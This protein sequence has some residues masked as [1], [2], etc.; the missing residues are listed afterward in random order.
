MSAAMPP[1]PRG[2]LRTALRLG[3]VS[4]VPT[5][6]TNVLAGVALA[7]AAFDPAY[8]APMALA[9]S[10]MYVAG[11]YLNDAFDRTW[12][13]THR[14]ERPIPAGHV[15]AWLVFVAGFTMLAAGVAVVAA[16]KPNF[17]VPSWRPTQVAIA[18]AIL[19]VYYDW[20]HKKN[21]LSPIVMGLCRVAV[22]VAAG[23][24]A[25]SPDSMLWWGSAL[26]LYHL[27][28]LS[29]IAK[30]E[31]RPRLE[32][33]W[34]VAVLAIPALFAIRAATTGGTPAI[35]L[36]AA[37]VAANAFAIAHVPGFSRRPKPQLAVPLLIANISLL[38]GVFIAGAGYSLVAFACFGA[39]ALT[40]ALQRLIPGT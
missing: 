29:Y 37:Y 4:N 18:L 33:L 2:R 17:L 21:A 38:D 11:M 7:G 15:P 23:L 3:R 35:V 24:A 39:W 1:S 22:Y 30:H 8:L 6:W 34:P 10:L 19:I 28:G 13:E 14:P 27:V 12:D 9:M 25:M 32:K 26:L 36:A 31:T 5:V 40:L 20:H 16:L